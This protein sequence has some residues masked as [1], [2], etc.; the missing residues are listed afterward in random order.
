M[1]YAL[2][3][4]LF[5]S[6]MA[7]GSIPADVLTRQAVMLITGG[8]L[9]DADFTV[10]AQGNITWLKNG[11]SPDPR[12]TVEA[13]AIAKANLVNISKPSAQDILAKAT[14]LLNSSV[15]S[16]DTRA[17]LLP[18]TSQVRAA[19]VSGDID[20]A[21]AVINKFTNPAD[22]GLT[23]EQ[24]SALKANVLALFP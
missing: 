20:A 12:V 9:T 21:K 19:L 16:A 24:F 2:F 3:A 22:S 6:N 13:L 15:P 18:M 11:G 8:E 4:L 5:I 23:D 14:A 7:L 17:A 1:K 10:D